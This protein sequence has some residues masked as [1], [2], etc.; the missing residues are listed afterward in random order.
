MQLREDALDV[1]VDR[2]DGDVS[3]AMYQQ[4]EWV[5]GSQRS[6]T[7]LSERERETQIIMTSFLAFSASLRTESR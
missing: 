6:S 3:A 2:L 1:V 5:V 7:S 4:F